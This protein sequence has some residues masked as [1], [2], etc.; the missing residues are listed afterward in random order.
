MREQQTKYLFIALKASIHT[1]ICYFSI[2]CSST[3]RNLARR[4]AAWPG[5]GPPGPAACRRDNFP[6][7][8]QHAIEK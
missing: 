1:K 4:R 3:G 7:G 8:G 6:P 2:V 5:G